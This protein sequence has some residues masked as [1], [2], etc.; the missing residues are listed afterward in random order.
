MPTD[1][2]TNMSKCQKASIINIPTYLNAKMSTCPKVTN[3]KQ[4][5]QNAN[6]QKLSQLLRTWAKDE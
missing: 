3:L 4:K 1:R 2:N 6:E 5:C